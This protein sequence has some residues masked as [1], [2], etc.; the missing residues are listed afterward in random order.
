MKT[1][2]HNNVLL[3]HSPIS[4]TKSNLSVCYMFPGG[5]KFCNKADLN[6]Y[7][8]GRL[9]P[10]KVYRVMYRA[11][12]NENTYD[13][14]FYEVKTGRSLSDKTPLV[15]THKCTYLNLFK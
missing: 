6:V 11:Y 1:P 8:N 4:H 13:S 10:N 5:N 14:P 15:L 12:D 2:Y 7:C 3:E 9:Q